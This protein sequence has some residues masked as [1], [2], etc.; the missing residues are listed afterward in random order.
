MRF[1]TSLPTN[2]KINESTGYYVN[3]VTY[4]AL[5]NVFV[6][7]QRGRPYVG[8]TFGLVGFGFGGAGRPRGSPS[9]PPDSFVGNFAVH[10][11]SQWG[12]SFLALKA[13][14]VAL[15]W[16]SLIWSLS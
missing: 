6:N 16:G 10:L 12:I 7:R 9:V 11:A 5:V 15:V 1:S 14:F 13:S 3:K 4:Q 8:H 2:F